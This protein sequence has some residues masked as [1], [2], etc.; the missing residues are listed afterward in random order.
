MNLD[1][2]DGLLG[3]LAV[4][5]VKHLALIINFLE[6]LWKYDLQLVLAGNHQLQDEALLLFSHLQRGAQAFLDLVGVILLLGID[7]EEVTEVC[8]RLS[9]LV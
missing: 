5:R 9:N 1:L 8:P 4:L 7:V 2:L 3:S 6:A